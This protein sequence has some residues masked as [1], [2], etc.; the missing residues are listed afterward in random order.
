[1]VVSAG[2][3][4]S[5]PEHNQ[6]VERYITASM[7]RLN[8]QHAEISVYAKNVFIPLKFD[9]SAVEK[10]ENNPWELIANATYD[11]NSS[12]ELHW[13]P[14]IVGA[15]KTDDQTNLCAPR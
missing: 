1:V 11:C 2:G 15:D 10:I 5:Q 4:S 13:C 9:F 3:E 14:R 8:R 6:V 12:P 7:H